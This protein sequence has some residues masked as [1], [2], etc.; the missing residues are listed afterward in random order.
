MSDEKNQLPGMGLFGWLGR[1]IG[2][3]SKAIKTDPAVVARE[4]NVEDKRDPE[5]PDLV[6]RR[7]TVDEVR[8]VTNDDAAQQNGPPKTTGRNECSSQ[9]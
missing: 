3:V 6:F 9:D 7:T 1:Q 4:T 5:H 8:R 2:Y